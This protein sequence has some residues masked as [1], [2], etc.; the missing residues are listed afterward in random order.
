[1]HVGTCL[2]P[3]YSSPISPRCTRRQNG[4]LYSTRVPLES[5]VSGA[6][7]PLLRGDNP[8]HK[9]T[10]DSIPCLQLVADCYC[11]GT[12]VPRHRPVCARMVED[13]R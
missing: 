3:P 10:K 13:K 9:S 8:V 4:P 11:S 7:L 1:M 6:P 12:I 5:L 2:T